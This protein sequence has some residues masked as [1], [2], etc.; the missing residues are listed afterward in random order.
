MN[1]VDAWIDA[2]PEDVYKPCLCGCGSVWRYVLKYGDVGI[3]EAKFV[4]RWEN[5]SRKSNAD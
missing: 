1:A 2:I 5:E 4:M 3:H